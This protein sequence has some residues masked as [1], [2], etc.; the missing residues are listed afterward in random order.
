MIDL[1]KKRQ[2]YWFVSKFI[3]LDKN[4]LY[5]DSYSHDEV[6]CFPVDLLKKEETGLFPLG[7]YDGQCGFPN[8]DEEYASYCVEMLEKIKKDLFKLD[9]LG[10]KINTKEFSWIKDEFYYCRKYV[11]AIDPYYKPLFEAYLVF[12]GRDEKECVAKKVAIS[13]IDILVDKTEK[14]RIKVY[15]NGDYNNPKDFSRNNSWGKMYELADVGFI[16]H[17]Y[18]FYNYFNFGEDNP[19][20]SKRCGFKITAI[21][22]KE[23]NLIV[24]NIEIK[25]ISKNKLSRLLKST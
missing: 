24:P 10:L 13:K 3:S 23:D 18:P 2:L 12:L 7:R 6:I 11:I 17:N 22:K 25:L 20:Y 4:Y 8:E 16:D 5:Q 9:H 15:I 21:V 14:K 19:L 1:L